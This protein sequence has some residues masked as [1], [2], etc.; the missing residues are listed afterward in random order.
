MTTTPQPQVDIEELEALAKA[1]PDDSAQGYCCSCGYTVGDCR[2]GP[3]YQ[4]RYA[5]K[6]HAVLALIAEVRALRP[7]TACHDCGAECKP[8]SAN[9][10][11]ELF[12]FAEPYIARGMQCVSCQ[13]QW[14]GAEAESAQSEAQYKLAGRAMRKAQAEADELRAVKLRVHELTKCH[15]CEWEEAMFEIERITR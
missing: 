11:L 9:R 10:V 12:G 2:C 14:F 15:G 7:S 4:L 13:V 3:R 1:C 5:T 8:F 6:K